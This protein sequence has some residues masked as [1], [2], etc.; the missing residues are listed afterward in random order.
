MDDLSLAKERLYSRNRRLVVVRAGRVV[1]ESDE[2]G[3]AATLSCLKEVRPQGPGFAV[4]DRVVGQAAA[5]L[6]LWAG[7]AAC[8]GQVLSRP[9][10]RVLKERGAV[11][12]A[13]LR[14]ENIL[15]RDRSGLCPLEAAVAE[16]GGPEEALDIIEILTG[17]AHA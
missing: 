13:S 9:A 1:A 7:A 2:P 5:W 16:A 11:V 17:R 10:E 15:N 4:A 12:K 8:Y 14:V 3:L 6:A